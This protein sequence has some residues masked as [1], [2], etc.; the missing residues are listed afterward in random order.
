MERMRAYTVP[1]PTLR[2]RARRFSRQTLGVPR[3]VRS[4]LRWDI[5]A[6]AFAGAYMGAVFPFVTRTA[7]ELHAPDAAIAWIN[8]APFLGNLLAP[9]W[10]R[11][12]NGRAKMPFCVWS[13]TIARLLLLLMPFAVAPWPFAL[14]ILS[15]Q[16]IGTISSPPCPA[17]RIFRLGLF[18]TPSAPP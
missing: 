14:L 12:M 1:V 17:I 7:K 4:T 10:A 11:Q 16:F 9:L 8:A 15:V 2:L 18:A 3:A 5:L 13:W 6:G